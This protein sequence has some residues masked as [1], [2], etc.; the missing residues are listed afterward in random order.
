MQSIYAC[1]QNEESDFN[2][3]LEKM[4]EDFRMELNLVGKHEKVRIDREKELAIALFKSRVPAYEQTDAPE[5]EIP[6]KAIEFADAAHSFFRS[7]KSKNLQIQKKRMLEET[8]ALYIRFLKLLKLLTDMPKMDNITG[9]TNNL[10]L[11][12]LQNSLEWQAIS[13]KHDLEWEA[14]IARQWLRMLKKDTELLA[15]LVPEERSFETDRNGLRM[16]IR[17]FL[18]KNEVVLSWFE[19]E[20]LKWS[21]NKAILKSLLINTVK[22][23]DQEN[24]ELSPVSAL[25]RNWED[26]RDFMLKLYDLY[27]NTELENEVL[28][29]EKSEKWAADRI[30]VLDKILIKMAINEMVN[31]PNIPVKVTINEYI[32]ISKTYSTPKSWKF[33]NGMLDEISRQLTEQGTIRKSGRGLIDNK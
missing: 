23:I 11:A 6:E 9:I 12:C 18:F 10:A 22:N 15:Q 17:D 20:D 32:D 27:F 31:F 13:K 19:E 24:A 25:S 5:E 16:V 29:A 1:K 28:V 3:A 21:E 26:D 30:A 2:I 7:R 14:G 4:S 8:E 33:I